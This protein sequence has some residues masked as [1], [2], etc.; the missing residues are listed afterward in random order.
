MSNKIKDFATGKLVDI[1]K[2]EEEVRQAY[3]R[4]LVNDF[5]YPKSAL[6][7]EVGIQMGSGRK[8]CDIAVYDTD[9]KRGK[10][11]GIIETKEP[12]VKIG[13][14]E[15]GQHK[16]YMSATISCKWGVLTNGEETHYAYKKDGEI[17]FSPAI[18]IPR[19]NEKGAV[20]LSYKALVKASNLKWTFKHINQRLYANTNL[21]RK[22][23]QGAE[24]SRLIFCKLTD[25]Y[26][27]EQNKTDIPAFQIKEGETTK[28]LRKRID[29][30]WEETKKGFLGEPIFDESEKIEI[31]DYSLELI[32]SLLQDYALLRTDKDVV[33]DAFEVFAERQFAG[34]KGQFFTPRSVVN[35]VIEMIDPQ[36]NDTIID[37]A[38]GSGGFLTAAFNHMT[39]GIPKSKTDIR[40]KIAQHSLYGIDKDADLVKICKAQMAIMGDGKSNIVQADSLKDPKEWDDITTSKLLE[41]GKQKQFDIVITNPPFG[42]KIKVNREEVLRNYELGHKWKA[43]SNNME[44]T[45]ITTPTP[46]QVLFIEKCL[47]LLKEGGKLGIVLPDGLL[48]N[49]GDVYI[50]QHIKDRAKVLAVIDCPVATFMPHTGTKTSVLILQKEK[51][52]KDEKIFFAIAENCGHTMRGKATGKNDFEL[53]TANYI[54]TQTGKNMIKSHL[55]FF[56]KF[57]DKRLI[58]APRY[59]DPRIIKEIKKFDGGGYEMTSIEEL[60]ESEMI[61]SV[62]TIQNSAT[63]EDYVIDGDIRFVRTSN[64]SGYEI[65]GTTQKTITMET[66][67]EKKRKQ[68]LQHGD[69]LFIKDGDTKIGECAILLTEDDL[70]ISVQSHFYKIRPNKMDE[71]LLL[72]ALNHPIVKKQI[73]QRV[74]SQSTLSTIGERIHELK[75]P[76]PK[77]Q[78][79]TKAIVKVMKKCI[80]ER[81]NRLD[82]I[83][84]ILNQ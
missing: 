67:N 21:S 50:R 54:K 40:G 68:D 72:W 39:K 4:I 15:F 80:K 66:Y 24:M 31:D 36:Q 29:G 84:N 14:K 52:V 16:S 25:E 9:R 2:P 71:F 70:Q 61:S 43:K 28:E 60:I 59:Y 81:R 30:L 27:G 73:R 23:K 8:K 38:C 35:M 45:N 32:V 3:E 48:G 51:T 83:N 47:N 69:I 17:E 34:D 82:E 11:V 78:S 19:Y 56:N 55:G 18:R 5:G 41:K 57:T 74:F 6:D 37:P 12:R 13:E 22:E 44:K 58:L 65:S 76:I 49:T 77:H 42:S 1:S 64:I 46:P 62:K 7:I 75:L 26:N 79:K 33:G 53:I 10:I 20:L 63:A